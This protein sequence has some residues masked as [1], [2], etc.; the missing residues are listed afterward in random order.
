MASPLAIVCILSALATTGCSLD[1]MRCMGLGISYCTEGPM[2]TCTSG[3]VCTTLYQV[4]ASDG[5]ASESVFRS[6]GPKTQC[7]KIG[8]FTVIDKRT[9]MGVSCCSTN[10]CTSPL[11]LL[12]PGNSAKNGKVCPS[13]ADENEACTGTETM[14]CLGNENQC[15][16]QV[17]KKTG[18]SDGVESYRGC[19]TKSVCDI[20]SQTIDFGVIKLEGKFLCNS[21]T[22][23]LYNGLFLM[24]ITALLQLK[25][26][27]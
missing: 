16:L 13:C 24:T 19:T 6:C 25:L 10:N 15:L 7:D 26:L 18:L 17:T 2:I 27:N 11:P 5:K 4:T 14:Q 9:R 1:C 21:G 3:E 8:S 23:A 12:I 20:G 22:N